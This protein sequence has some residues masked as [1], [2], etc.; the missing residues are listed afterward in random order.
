MEQ[1][2]ST[3][4]ATVENFAAAV[5]E[6][7][8]AVPVLVDFWAPWC[9]PCRTL[10]PVLDRIAD[11]YAGRLLLAKLNID[12]QQSVAAHFGIRSIPTV[13]LFHRGQVAERFTGVQ[14]DAAIRAL[15]DRHVA[16]SATDSGGASDPVELSRAQ[17]LAGDPAAAAAILEQALGEQPE[18][19]PLLVARAELDLSQR[20]A[21]AASASLA[22]IAAKDPQHPALR[23]LQAR[24]EFVAAVVAW[25]DPG[26]ARAAVE[27]DPA[28]SAARH[29][30]AA[31]HALAGDYATALSEWLELMR[32]DRGYGDDVAR[33][34]LLGV[35]AMLGSTHELVI[36]YR[37]RMA[38]LLH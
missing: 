4:V 8:N 2:A 22:R 24:L 37:R 21:K 32:R 27:A 25:P 36:G 38:S 6:A 23:S 13:V 14:P 31:H 28:D 18:A 30:L 7:S 35:F 33:R 3:L 15:L 19:L 1:A 16:A 20:N 29:A 11:D 34:S 26:T 10:M 9:A 5:V 17:S 12:E